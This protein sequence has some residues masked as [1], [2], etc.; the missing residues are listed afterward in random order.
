MLQFLDKQAMNYTAILGLR[1]SLHLHGQDY[2]WAGSIFY[3]GY[4][5]ASY[6]VARALVRFPLGRT[7]AASMAAWSVVLLC[8]AAT[9]SAAGLQATRFFLGVCEAAVAPGFSLV[10]A[11]WWRRG[12]QPARHG[13]WFMG[14][15]AAGLFGAVLAWAV[16][17]V[18]N[19]A[20][21][22]WRVVFLVFGGVTLVWSGVVWW[23][24]PSAVGRA[25]FLPRE[26][27][28]E[29]A[30]RRV[31]GNLGVAGR[32]GEWK[33]EQVWEAVRDPQSWLFVVIQFCGQIPNGGV[34]N[35][36]FPG[37]GGPAGGF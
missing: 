23:G 12:E 10:T 6:P 13:A 16:G 3:L 26:G 20:I 18:D 8:T 9:T 21:E 30:V 24:V 14:N 32:R 4:L 11:A 29:R 31:R 25:W 27:D 2:A 28:G 34:T 22:A 36:S 19:P 33:G 7:L 17:H 1:P 15:V 37:G 5:A 35:V